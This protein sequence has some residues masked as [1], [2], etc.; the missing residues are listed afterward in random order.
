MNITLSQ[1]RTALGQSLAPEF[2]SRGFT[3]NKSKF[4]FTKKIEKN[5]VKCV[6]HFYSFP[7]ERVEFKFA[8]HFTIYEIEEE[9]KKFC[10]Y[11]GR[12]YTANFTFA[13][14]EGDLQPSTKDKIA[15]Y[16]YAYTHVV[17]D[18]T[19]T[20]EIDDCKRILDGFFPVINTI[21]DILGLQDYI[22]T[23]ENLVNNIIV[24]I[25]AAKLKD[26]SSFEEM[27][28][29]VWQRDELSANPGLK[30]WLDDFVVYAKL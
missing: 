26:R 3:F 10:I 20:K 4:E 30:K 28:D 1:L 5:K 29:L 19:N 16:R 21:S 23:N 22:F 7:P 8:F 2:T 13:V 12:D 11:S 27:L 18:V 6:F 9:I 15:K 14:L 25:V 17:T 24:R